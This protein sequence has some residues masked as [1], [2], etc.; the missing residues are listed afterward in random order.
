ML[1]RKI[2]VVVAPLIHLPN[3]P[4]N[5]LFHMM[6]DLLSVFHNLMEIIIYKCVISCDVSLLKL[7]KKHCDSLKCRQIVKSGLC[8]V[9]KEPFFVL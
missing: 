1:K 8:K 2:V 9:K 7:K 6:S 3:C 4:W 5:I